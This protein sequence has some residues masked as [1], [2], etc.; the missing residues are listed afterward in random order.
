MDNKE[1][2]ILHSAI[3]GNELDE[4]KEPDT[5][6]SMLK[7]GK[8]DIMMSLKWDEKR[9]EEFHDYH[10]IVLQNINENGRVVFYNPMG[11]EN[12]EAGTI[13]KGE[14]MGPERL[15][16]DI[17]LE[18]VTKDDFIKFFNEREAVCFVSKE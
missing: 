11:H 9:G 3:F 7:E 18:S 14:N 8:S 2:H 5:I 1:L 10:K 6:L 12:M 17:G 16:E 13:I 15:I 4:V